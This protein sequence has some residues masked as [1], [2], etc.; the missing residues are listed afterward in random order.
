MIFFLAAAVLILIFFIIRAVRSKGSLRARSAIL[1]AGFSLAVTALV[2]PYFMEKENGIIYALFK[3][4][5]YGVSSIAMGAD[6]QVTEALSDGTITGAVSASLLYLLYIAGP[7]TASVFLISFS[8]NIIERILQ[9]GSRQEHVFSGLNEKT[10][11]IAESIHSSS[12]RDMITFADTPTDQDNDLF[13]RITRIGSFLQKG[14]I[15]KKNL[16]RNRRYVFYV[17]NDDADKNLS[18]LSALCSSLISSRRYEKGN[19]TVRYLASRN[20]LDLIRDIDSR[21]GEKSRLKAS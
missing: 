21:F 4:V 12:P 5:R 1:T 15:D 8:R 13:T 6:S 3:S 16:R 20:S 14:G 7:V 18:T 19:V 11:V 17:I 9:C 10:A 2:L